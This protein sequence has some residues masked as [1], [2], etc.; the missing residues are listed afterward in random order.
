MYTAYLSNSS[1]FSPFRLRI[2]SAMLIQPLDDAS[3]ENSELSAQS[4]QITAATFY[5][6]HYEGGSYVQIKLFSLSLIQ[7]WRRTQKYGN[8]DRI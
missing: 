6:Y 4:V 3:V 8:N 2:Y 5:K 1:I 7:K